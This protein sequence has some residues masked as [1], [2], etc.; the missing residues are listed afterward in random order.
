MGMGM[1]MV[2]PLIFAVTIMFI[3][4]RFKRGSVDEFSGIF[5]L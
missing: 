5:S 1:G 3:Y 4:T 2:L